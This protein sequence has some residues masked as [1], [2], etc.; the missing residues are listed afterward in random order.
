LSNKSSS[1][2]AKQKPL[3]RQERAASATRSRRATSRGLWYCLSRSRTQTV[4]CLIAVDDRVA[5]SPRVL[6]AARRGVRI[7]W[8]TR[9]LQRYQGRCFP[10]VN[11]RSRLSALTVSDAFYCFRKHATSR[12]HRPEALKGGASCVDHLRGRV[13]EIARRWCDRRD[14]EAKEWLL[15]PEGM[16]SVAKEKSRMHLIELGPPIRGSRGA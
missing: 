12:T 3:S 4:G 11:P 7:D 13:G 8:H 2:N 9:T 1:H 6:Q 14:R 5:K 10:S 16:C 15:S